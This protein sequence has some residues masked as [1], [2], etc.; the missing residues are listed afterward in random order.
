M[1][2]GVNPLVSYIR[3]STSSQGRSGLGLEAQRNAVARFAQVEGFA[4]AGEHIEVET[5]KGADALERRPQLKAALAEARRLKCPVVVAKLDRL[6]RDV[7][8]ISG[9][10]A[11][12]VAF[13]VADLGP[14]VDP[15]MLHIYAAVAEKERAMI[16]VRTREA[17]ARAK[18]RGVVLGNP[19]LDQAQPRGAAG[20]RAAAERFA[21]G[22]LPIV[23]P[24]R[25]QG[26]SLRAIVEILDVRG[27]STARGGRWAPTQ[28]ADVLRRRP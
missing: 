22:V 3:V 18:A 1:Q 8:F 24:L 26:L 19:R 15:F 20:M 17:L 12:K 25:D 21:A 13:V 11:R 9:L 4:I 23:R 16:G 27:V 6:S 28:V 7:A 2:P 5:G 14:E 10:M